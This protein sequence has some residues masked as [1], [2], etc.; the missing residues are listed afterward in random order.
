MSHNFHAV[1]SRRTAQ[2]HYHARNNASIHEAHN[3]DRPSLEMHTWMIYSTILRH[4]QT[5]DVAKPITNENYFKKNYRNKACNQRSNLKCIIINQ[6]HLY[7]HTHT[8]TV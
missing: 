8:Q 2:Y 3:R 5:M 1:L 7:T 6:F 4:T